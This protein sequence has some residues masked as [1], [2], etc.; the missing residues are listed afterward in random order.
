VYDTQDLYKRTVLLFV[1]EN[2]SYF[3]TSKLEVRSVGH[4]A[5]NGEERVQGF[6][7]GNLMERDHWRDPGVDWSIIL[8][9]ISN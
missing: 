1:F 4:V 2:A 7:S 6:G 9:W 8:R 3:K 5:R